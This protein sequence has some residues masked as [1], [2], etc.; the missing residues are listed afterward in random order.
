MQFYNNAYA[1]IGEDTIG[2]DATFSSNASGSPP[3]FNSS[4]ID[5]FMANSTQTDT[6]F[7]NS[8]IAQVNFNTSDGPLPG[9]LQI[10]YTGLS[11]Y[12]ISPEDAK[13]F[14]LNE[15]T[16]AMI[17][18]EVEPRSPAALAGIMG[19]NLTTSVRGDIVKLG[20]DLILRIDGND[21]YI[22]TN[23]AFLNYLQNQKRVGEN[24]T[25]TTLRNGQ[26]SDVN[27]TIGALPR[28]FWYDNIDEGIRIKYPSDWE[29]SE[30]ESIDEIVKFFTP[31]AVRIDNGTEPAAGIF[32][33]ISAA[34]DV[35]LDDL[36]ERE[37]RDSRDRRNLDITLT[38][39]SNLPAY[40][41]VFYD[42]SANRTLKKFSAFTINDG[43]VYRINFA[44]DP[45][46]Y[47][48]YLP[49]AKEVINSFQFIR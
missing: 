7:G 6:E 44:T 4:L 24:L 31:N 28:Y 1:T 27:V 14:G 38:D 8:D 13:L 19:G 18:T 39:I 3:F 15:N 43:M 34:G 17:V 30:T 22:R 5:G 12:H 29:I 26:I 41:A 20:G 9:A 40:E 42:Y 47:N 35:G 45:S 10:P 25:L 11:R 48:D 2:T 49:L 46:R 36:A 21:T 23:E 33:L 37:Q 16:P 32:V